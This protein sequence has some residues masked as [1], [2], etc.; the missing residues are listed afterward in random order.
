[1]HPDILDTALTYL[2]TVG[3]PLSAFEGLRKGREPHDPDLWALSFDYNAVTDDQKVFALKLLLIMTEA[4]E[5]FEALL[6]EPEK[7]AEEVAD[8]LIRVLEFAR[9]RNIDIDKAVRDKMEINKN[10]P[11]KHGKR[12]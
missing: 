3:D 10:R 12:F 4:Y 7:E 5:T 2:C 8:I 9:E 1:M 11:F 6:V